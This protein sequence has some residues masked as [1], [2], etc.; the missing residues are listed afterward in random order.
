MNKTMVVYDV[1]GKPSGGFFNTLIDAQRFKKRDNNKEIIISDDGWFVNDKN[2]DLQGV[3]EIRES[4]C[5]QEN[6]LTGS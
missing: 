1:E 6:R 2:N 5:E 4:E 3:T